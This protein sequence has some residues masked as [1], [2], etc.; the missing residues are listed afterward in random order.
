MPPRFLFL[1][2][3]GDLVILNAYH[4]MRIKNS[5]DYEVGSAITLMDG[6]SQ[7]VDESPL[8]IK[9]ILETVKDA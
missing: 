4:V 3:K 9:R 8:A 6:K 7:E 1:H 2:F 5:V